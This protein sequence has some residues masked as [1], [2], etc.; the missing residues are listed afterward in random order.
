MKA[1]KLTRRKPVS[2]GVQFWGSEGGVLAGV[3]LPTA[4]AVGRASSTVIARP[5]GRWWLLMSRRGA[6]H[7]WGP[8]G[9]GGCAGGRPEVAT[10]MEALTVAQVEGIWW[11]R[12]GPEVDGIGSGFEKL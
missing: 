12:R 11:W 6:V 7:R 4:S 9:G 3:R 8:H 5:K 1:G 2:S 10:H